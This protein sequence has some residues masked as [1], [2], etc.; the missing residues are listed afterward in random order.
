MVNQGTRLVNCDRRETAAGTAGRAAPG[1]ILLKA[2]FS[3]YT[4][5]FKRHAAVRGYCQVSAPS[6]FDNAEC[7]QFGEAANSSVNGKSG[8]EA[9]KL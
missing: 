2:R 3:D 1:P 8:D 7:S 5:Y 4:Q 9:C 6:I